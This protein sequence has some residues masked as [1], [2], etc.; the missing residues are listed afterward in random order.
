MAYSTRSRS[1]VAV[2]RS[3]ISFGVPGRNAASRKCGA[4]GRARGIPAGVV[5]TMRRSST[6]RIRVS[7]VAPIRLRF[8]QTDS[9]SPSTYRGPTAG[10]FD[11]SVCLRKLRVCPDLRLFSVGESTAGKWENQSDPPTAESC[12]G[13][14]L[15]AMRSSLTVC[16]NVVVLTA[17]A[18]PGGNPVV[19]LVCESD[20]TATCHLR[21]FCVGHNGWPSRSRRFG[22]CGSAPPWRV[23]S[24][25]VPAGVFAV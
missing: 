16:S 21:L 15:V 23:G 11:S 8:L 20:T 9:S 25:T 2:C 4:L 19:G 17:Y 24:V 18:T 10:H 7:A 22:P 12:S 14:G 3:R 13:Y 1:S 5:S 6:E